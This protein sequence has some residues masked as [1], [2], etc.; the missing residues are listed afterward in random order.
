MTNPS[1]P[2]DEASSGVPEVSINAGR[3]RSASLKATKSSRG[4]KLT[5]TPA[6]PTSVCWRNASMIEWKDLQIRIH[7]ESAHPTLIYLPGLH[8]DWTLISSFREAIRNLVRLVDITYT[9]T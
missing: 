4:K 7:G 6:R 2:R 8:G 9:S 5:L 1:A 3:K